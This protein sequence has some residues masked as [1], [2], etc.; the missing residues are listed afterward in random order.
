[1]RRRIGFDALELLRISIALLTEGIIL[2]KR[3]F[4]LTEDEAD[5]LPPFTPDAE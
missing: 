5:W 4:T 2:G 3:D 1:L